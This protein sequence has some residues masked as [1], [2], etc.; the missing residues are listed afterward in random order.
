MAR[1]FSSHELFYT[2]AAVYAVLVV[3]LALAA[4]ATRGTWIPGLHTPAGHAHEMLVGYALAVVAGNQLGA[5]RPRVIAALLLLWVAARFAFVFAPESVLSAVV[6]AAFAGALAW[7]VLPRLVG[8]AKKWRNRA[9]PAVLAALC[10]MAAYWEYARGVAQPGAG[11]PMPYTMMLTFITLFALLMLFMGGRILAPAIAGQYHHQ[12]QNL[13]ARVQPRIEAVL[14]VAGMLT[15]LAVAVP[16]WH[17]WAS[18]SAAIA[19][20]LALVRLLRWRLW[21]VHGRVDLWCLASGYAWLGVGLLALA[22]PLATGSQG[23]AAA[24]VVTV[25][26]LGTLTF[27]VMSQYWTLRA[28][29]GLA[30]LK[31]IVWGTALLAAATV[32]RVLGPL[33]AARAWGWMQA[34]SLCWSAAFALLL[35]LFW[36][37]RTA[38]RK[39]PVHRG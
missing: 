35:G 15:S 1:S 18:V 19:G 25:G 23:V 34:A 5:V 39:R 13:E 26:A 22:W 2:A 7:R 31:L 24:H 30:D 9:L 29:R 11:G 21:G 12:G 28:R 20:A 8:A 14:L 3:P 37:C 17:S 10:S 27:N 4:M 6:N 38:L 16:A 36:R 32:F 33:D